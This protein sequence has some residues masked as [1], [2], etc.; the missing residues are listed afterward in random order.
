MFYVKMLL[1]FAI[2]IAAAAATAATPTT[3]TTTTTT[4]TTTT[5]TTAIMCGLSM[6]CVWVKYALCVG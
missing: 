6:V 1:Q 4:T 2:P 3:A 5:S